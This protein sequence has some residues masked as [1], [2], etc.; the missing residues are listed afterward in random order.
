MRTSPEAR[1]VFSDIFT[2]LSVAN[3]VAI[4]NYLFQHNWLQLT[5]ALALS[6]LTIRFA[7]Q[8]RKNDYEEPK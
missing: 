1:D 3:V 6:I 4:P 5:T 7:I 2:D 8:L